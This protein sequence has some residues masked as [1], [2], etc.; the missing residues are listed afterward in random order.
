ME[1]QKRHFSVQKVLPLLLICFFL[2][3][4]IYHN[5]KRKRAEFHLLVEE[6]AKILSEP[7]WAYNNIVI[8]EIITATITREEYEIIKIFDPENSFYDEALGPPPQGAAHYLS[9]WN[10]IPREKISQPIIKDGQHIGTLEVTR[11]NTNIFINTYATL[12]AILFY[13]ISFLYG[14][15]VS[16]NQTLKSKIEDLHIAVEEVRRQKEFVENIFNVAPQGMIAINSSK[17]V[18]EYNTAFNKIITTWSEK[19]ENSPEKTHD[20]II[21]NLL[22]QLDQ[23][24]EGEFTIS[25]EGYPI[26]LEYS[27]AEI[28]EFENIELVISLR[29]ITELA[30]MRQRLTQTEKLESVGQLAAGIAHEI[31]TPTQYVSS[32]I[33]FLSEAFEDTLTCFEEIAATLGDTEK[34]DVAAFQKKIS[35]SLEEAD[36]EFLRE[37]IPPS[38]H[39]SKEGLDRIQSIVSAM[40][41]FSHP[42]GENKDECDINSAIE[43]T[44]TV[45]RNEWKYCADVIFNLDSSLPKVPGYL[46]QLN[47][48]ILILVVNAAHAIEELRHEED[49]EKGKITIRTRAAEDHIILSV[50]DTGAGIP[51]K[52]LGKIFDPFFTTKTVGQGSGQGLTIAN[53]IIVNKHSG[54]IDVESE[55]GKGSTFLVYLPLVE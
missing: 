35:T 28:S 11:R 54:R 17:Q 48:V 22:I 41:H 31:N 42:S 40:K 16:T 46:D 29:D 7:M 23:K 27:S 10:L 14:R 8:N 25:I 24:S 43:T 34:N 15:I 36:W 47:Q 3:T 5:T 44:V 1:Q 37:E 2:F 50:T 19:V 4:F 39:Q 49:A 6:Q 26:S 12:L 38:L 53:D 13:I 30:T 55:V 52:A 20:I 21:E 9:K 32:N 45:A 33:S 18:V 51:E